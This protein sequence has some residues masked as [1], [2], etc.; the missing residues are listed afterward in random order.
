[1]NG[2]CLYPFSL[3]EAVHGWPG[4]ADHCACVYACDAVLKLVALS[5]GESTSCDNATSIGTSTTMDWA[6][7]SEE[8]EPMVKDGDMPLLYHV[9]LS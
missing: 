3:P 9:Q 8:E 2:G 5:S 6:G 1:M 4:E 7:G